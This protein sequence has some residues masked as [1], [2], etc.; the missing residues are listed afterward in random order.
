[1]LLD[2]ELD[3]CIEGLLTL[4]DAFI[5]DIAIGIESLESIAC[6]QVEFKSIVA[7]YMNATC[8]TTREQVPAFVQVKWNQIE[9]RFILI[10]AGEVGTLAGSQSAAERSCAGCRAEERNLCDLL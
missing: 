5:K 7:K 6:I 1:M 4:F 9:L 3:A 2:S 8:R 10:I